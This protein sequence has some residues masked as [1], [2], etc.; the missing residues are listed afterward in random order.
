MRSNLLYAKVTQ[1]VK[2]QL[3]G[4]AHLCLNNQENLKV[5]QQSSL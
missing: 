1:V 4:M 5:V 2:S 3:T